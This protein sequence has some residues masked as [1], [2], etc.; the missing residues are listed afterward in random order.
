VHTRLLDGTLPVAGLRYAAMGG[1][2]GVEAVVAGVCGAR[3][4]YALDVHPESVRTAARHYERIVG[5]EG[6][7]L[8]PVVADVW[9]G[10]PDGVQVDVVTFNPPAVELPLADDPDVVRNTCV[11]RDIAVRFFDQLMSRDLLASGGVV[12]LVVSNTAALRDIVAVALDAG[13]DAEV[14]HVQD[15]PD[16]DAQTYLFALRHESRV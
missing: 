9:D 12:Y 3:V 1:G 2:V 10:F 6:P 14:V 13:F 11:G 7:P 16:D 5:A 4:V 8:V 15:W